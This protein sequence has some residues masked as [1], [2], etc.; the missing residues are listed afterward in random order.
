VVAVRRRL[1]SPTATAFEEQCRA[2]CRL[3]FG[4]DGT[5][6]ARSEGRVRLLRLM[7]PPN[8]DTSRPPVI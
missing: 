1:R 7:A 8:P 6:K 3:V 5:L 4:H 2:R